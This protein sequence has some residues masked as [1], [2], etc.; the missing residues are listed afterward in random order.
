M[1]IKLKLSEED[2]ANF[3]ALAHDYG[4]SCSELLT[5]FVRDLV[6]S[7]ESNGSDERTLAEDYLSRVSVNWGEL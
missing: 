3:K 7:T 6:Y 2:K 1:Q 5:N 4:V